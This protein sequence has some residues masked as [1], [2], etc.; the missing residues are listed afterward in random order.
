MIVFDL[1]RLANDQTKM[2]LLLKQRTSD[3]IYCYTNPAIELFLL[4][5]INQSYEQIIEPRTKEILSNEKNEKGERFV[6]RLALDNIP[7]Y[8]KRTDADFRFILD[9]INVACNKKKGLITNYL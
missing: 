3:I 7:G 9:N 4:L 6:Y 5:T 1:D 2:D 8:S